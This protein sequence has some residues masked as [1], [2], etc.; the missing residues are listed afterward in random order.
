MIYVCGANLG[1]QSKPIAWFNSSGTQLGSVGSTTYVSQRITLDASTGIYIVGSK[2]LTGGYTNSAIEKYT[3]GSSSLIWGRYY[4][5]GLTGN[6]MDIGL[7]GSSNS[8]VVVTGWFKGTVNF[9]NGVNSA[10]TRTSSGSGTH[11]NIF[12]ARYKSGLGDCLWVENNTSNTSVGQS[13]PIALASNSTSFNVLGYVQHRTIN[14]DLCGGTVNIVATNANNSYIARYSLQAPPSGTVNGPS[15]VCAGGAQYTVINLPQGATLSSWSATSNININPATGYAVPA[16]A[17][18]SGSGQVTANI[19]FGCGQFPITK[20]ISWVGK[21]TFTS[22]TV[23]GSTYY[24]G[25]CHGVC[26]GYHTAHLTVNG[27]SALDMSWNL[28]PGGTVNWQWEPY[29]SQVVFEV[30]PFYTQ[31][32]FNFVGS[33]TNQCGTSQFTFCFISGPNCQQSFAFSPNP[34]TNELTLTK[35][36]QEDDEP[37]D[38]AQVALYDY[39]QNTVYSIDSSEPKIVIPVSGLPAGQYYLQITNKKGMMK[40]KVIIKK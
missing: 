29:N 6:S 7:T 12:V 15:L 16:S 14:L 40:E 2:T 4:S 5:T 26:P 20:T 36:A 25:S 9:N 22:P 32:P 39:Q 11:D 3:T 19:S 33:S 21:P 8:E 18:S 30:I 23:D 10:F 38:V 24:V 34:A 31:F 37:T 35:I 28:N 17:Y 27:A 1:T 13:D